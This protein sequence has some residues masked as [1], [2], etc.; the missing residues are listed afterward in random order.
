MFRA[1]GVDII[2][3]A[4]RLVPYLPGESTSVEK[5]ETDAAA[6]EI[7]SEVGCAHR[8]RR[9]YNDYDKKQEEVYTGNESI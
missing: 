3:Q 5:R 9:K 2:V 1:Q 7:S 8:G 6:V 4:P